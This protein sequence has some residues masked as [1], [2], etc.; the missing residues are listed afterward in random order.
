MEQK[1]RNGRDRDL[2]SIRRA[3]HVTVMEGDGSKIPDF[4][5]NANPVENS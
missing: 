2:S 5:K 3:A 1:T 4:F